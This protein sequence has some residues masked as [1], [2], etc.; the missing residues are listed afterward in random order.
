M[1]K[2]DWTS[3]TRKVAVKSTVQK[4]Y[5]AW[6]KSSEIEKW[7]LLKSSYYTNEKR[8]LDANES[9][10]K[11]VGYKWTWYIYDGVEDG[12]ITEANAKDFLQFTFAGECLV[13]IS[14]EQKDEY[15]I[16]QLTQK[17][18][19]TDEDSK[20]N[21]RMGCDSGWSFYLLN[22]KSFYE[23]GIDLRNKNPEFKGSV[24]S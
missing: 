10:A 21:I 7:F 13:D 6:T 11:G 20:K 3:F 15:V 23:N 24:N 5:D 22:L 2:I 14:L 17:N 18:I 8:L 9:V 19:P 12:R 4:M 1:D 16:V